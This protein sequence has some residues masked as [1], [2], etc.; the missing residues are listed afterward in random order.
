M[1]AHASILLLLVATT[2]AAVH[3]IPLRPIEPNPQRSFGDRVRATRFVL[4]RRYGSASTKGEEPLVNFEDAQYYGEISIG[5]PPQPFKVIFDTG[6]SN[7]WVPSKEC[8]LLDL[9]CKA[10]EKYDH[11]KS[12]TYVKNG[13][14]FAI[15]YGSGQMSGFL[16][17]DTL[18][19]A[20]LT[21]QN[22]TFAE[23]TH[24]PGLSFI[25]AKFDG[26]L[27]MG[28]IEI[29]VEGVVPPFYLMA[30]QHLVKAPIY[31]FWLNRIIEPN[32]GGSLDLGGDDPSH[33]SGALTY[34]NLTKDGYWQFAL[35]DMVVAGKGSLCKEP[36]QA[37]ADTGTS[38][39][40]G[41]TDAVKQIQE[42]IGAK[43]LV[44]GEY[45]VD[46]SSIPSLPTISF[47][48]GGKT[49]DLTGKDYVLQVSGM[50]LSGFMGIDFPLDLSG[51]WVTS[52]L[53]SITPSSILQTIAL[54]TLWR[55][56][57]TS[58]ACFVLLSSF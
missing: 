4:E 25:V 57:W 7:L 37:I 5:T 46:C 48:L 27:G 38:L 40:A 13:T 32:A 14:K 28:W 11:T 18:T 34:V 56:D 6:S 17:Q 43:P 51:F 55:S 44:E 8:G 26:I 36:C 22:V 35:D 20:G 39:M 47:K 45:T 24:E 3:N 41:P 31:A 9:A 29:S 50:C 1:L 15:Q 53:E 16:S 58:F 33:Y 10:H 23:A 21:V 12:S 42:W 2:F 19:V 52:S 54:D 49:F 30:Q